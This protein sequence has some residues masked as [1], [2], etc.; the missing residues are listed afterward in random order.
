MSNFILY[1]GLLTAYLI[2]SIP[3]AYIFGRVIK[4]IDIRKFGS[5]NV[6][7]TNTFR[8]MG[9]FPGLV[10]LFI[11][12][13]KG[14]VCATYIANVFMLIS[15]VAR[16]ELYRVIMGLGAIAGHNWSVFLKFKGGKGVATSSGVVIG[17]IPKMFVLGFFVWL[18][19]FLVTGFVSLA[20]IIASICVP[21]F[22]F[23]F[24]APT[25]IV[26]FMCV[27]CI[28]IV[29]RHRSNIRRLLKGEEKRIVI[30]KRYTDLHR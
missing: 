6:G 18:V 20:S 4:G 27:L 15:P 10:V 19:V 3:T 23:I 22:T 11:D 25:E 16:P 21:I 1:S 17:L 5:G 12:I 7:A 29:Y 26:I 30:F 9:R 24:G 28:A 8:V 14:F 13:F 2:G